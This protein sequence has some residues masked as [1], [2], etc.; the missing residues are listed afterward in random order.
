MCS[1]RLRVCQYVICCLSALSD[2]NCDLSLTVCAQGGCQHLDALVSDGHSGSIL[3]GQ[4]TPRTEAGR[5]GAGRGGGSFRGIAFSL[6]AEWE[7]SQ[8]SQS[9]ASQRCQ[10]LDILKNIF[11]ATTP[12]H[13]TVATQ[14]CNVHYGKVHSCSTAEN[15]HFYGLR[16]PVD[17]EPPHSKLLRLA[18]H[19]TNSYYIVFYLC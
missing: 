6:S 3:R 10:S 4:R 5:H 18:C 7:T 15:G 14:E 1:C 19:F 2:D 11:A 17:K 12:K 16:V 8:Q 13:Y 9:R